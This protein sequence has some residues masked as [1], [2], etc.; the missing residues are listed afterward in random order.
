MQLNEKLGAV[1]AI[2][3][4]SGEP[5]D[6]HRISEAAGVD[7]NSISGLVKALNDRYRDSESALNIVR[8]GNGYQMCTKKEYAEYIRA[9]MEYKKQIP[10]SN[11]AMEALTVIAYNQ[12]VTKSFVENVRGIDS[13]SVINSLVDKGLLEEAGRLEVPGRPV[14]YKT[15]DN[16][17]RCFGLSSLDDLPPLVREGDDSQTSLF[18]DEC[19]NNDYEDND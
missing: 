7:K 9:A 17:L 16:F 1:E 19:D 11:A 8:L 6:E 4:A 3:F 14:A 18:D 5:V 2:L 15:T 12:P 10:L 13:S